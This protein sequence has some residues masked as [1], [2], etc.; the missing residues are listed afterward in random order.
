MELSFAFLHEGIELSQW[1]ILLAGY[2]K[3]DF[4]GEKMFG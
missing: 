1:L 2:E 3:E 4:V